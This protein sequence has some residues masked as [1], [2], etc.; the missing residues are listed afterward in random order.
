MHVNIYR[1]LLINPLPEDQKNYK[2]LLFLHNK[3]INNIKEGLQ[4]SELYNKVKTSFVEKFPDLETHLP[5]YFGF[6]IGYEFR[7]KLLVIQAK[8]TENKIQRGNVFAIT[9]SLKDLKNSKK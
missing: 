3:V 9:T 6:G 8:N 5:S 2:A 1:T 7:E 4:F